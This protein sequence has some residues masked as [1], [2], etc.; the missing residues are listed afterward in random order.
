[1]I[2][3]LVTL[4][5]I[6]VCIL[7]LVYFSNRSAQKND[8]EIKDFW[9]KKLKEA[10]AQ[11]KAFKE[12]ADNYMKSKSSKDFDDIPREWLE[13]EVDSPKKKSQHKNKK[14]TGKTKQIDTKKMSSKPKKSVKNEVH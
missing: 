12:Y 11:E 14:S 9:S 5:I 7:A 10:E 8:Q 6:I 1:M 4:S 3:S 2:T 13:V